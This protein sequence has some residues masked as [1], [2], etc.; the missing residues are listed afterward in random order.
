MREIRA[1]LDE[2]EAAHLNFEGSNRDGSGRLMPCFWLDRYHIEV[3]VTGHYRRP[4]KEGD[5]VL[6]A[7]PFPGD[8]L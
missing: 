3:L 4:K 6:V 7:S 8:Q 2:L 1:M 5:A